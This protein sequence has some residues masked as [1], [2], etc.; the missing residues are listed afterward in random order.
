[1]KV[2]TIVTDAAV[3]FADIVPTTKEII[4]D[5][6]N[7][8]FQHENVTDGNPDDFEVCYS[9]GPM[10]GG[11]AFITSKYGAHYVHN[12]SVQEVVCD[13]EDQIECTIAIYSLSKLSDDAT[14]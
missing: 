10:N 11:Q 9:S 12:I 1:M 13:D 8:I 2:I 4:L 5:V 6:F 7:R 14:N 3:N